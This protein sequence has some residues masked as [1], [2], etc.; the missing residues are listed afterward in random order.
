[1]KK[2]FVLYSVVVLFC[3]FLSRCKV[4]VS[5]SDETEL[6]APKNFSAKGGN[7]CVMLV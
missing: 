6:L 7:S 2:D 4:S 1:M 3:L 5:S